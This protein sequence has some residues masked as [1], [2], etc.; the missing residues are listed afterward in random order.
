MR[1]ARRTFVL[2]SGA[3]L[4]AAAVAAQ[5]AREK[6]FMAV[7][8]TT[9]SMAIP[10]LG[11]GLPPGV[12]LNALPPEAREALGALL[13]PQKM[14]EVRLWSPGA[15]PMSATANLDIPAALK[16]GQTLPLE[17]ARPEQR[18]VPAGP[19]PGRQAR[20]GDDFEIRLYWGCSETVP[21]GQPK[22]FRPADLA[23]AER[24]AWRR[25]ATQSGGIEKPDW[26]EAA[27][28]NAKQAPGAPGRPGQAKSKPGSLKGSYT[29]RTTYLGDAPFA[30]S[31]PVD[32]LEGVTFTSPMPGKKGPD[33]KRAI[34]VAWKPIP[35]VLGYSLFATAIKGEK[36]MIMWAAGQNSGGMTGMSGFPSMAEVRE[37]VQ[38][39][40]FLPPTTNACAIPA[41]IFEGAQGAMV[42]MTAFGPGQAFEAPNMPNIR[43]QTKSTGMLPLMG[44]EGFGE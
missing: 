30:V 5:E 1:L 3:S 27:W 16:L 44:G 33:L 23:P 15:A 39:G 7:W 10:G 37:L 6:A 12:D 22:V 2:G 19:A 42:H 9:Q 29:L 24:E 28:P 4:I 36:L 17:I 14:L 35:N 31:D 18:K 25:M 11:A 38:K 13:G 8:A 32:F 20:I 40:I 26:T 43:V 41:G 34:P 21:A